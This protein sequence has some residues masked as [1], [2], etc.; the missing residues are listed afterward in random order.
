[1]QVVNYQVV[2]LLK[3]SWTENFTYL[4]SHHWPRNRHQLKQH[5]N[6]HVVNTAVSALSAVI[7][8]VQWVLH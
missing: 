7:F 2:K 8:E 4:F 3:N 6:H 5:W 1:L